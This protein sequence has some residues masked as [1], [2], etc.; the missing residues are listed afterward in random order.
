M[1]D[2][3]S[4]RKAEE[5]K[6]PYLNLKR[7]PFDIVPSA[8]GVEHWVGRPA[9]GK[10]LQ[11][12][13]HSATRVPTSRIV[14]LWATFG[15][16]KTHALRHVEY[17]AGNSNSLAAVYVA[18]PRGIRSFLDIYK[19][20]IDALI[21]KGLLENIGHEL[22]R[23]R[24]AAVATDSERALVRLA[25]GSDEEQRIAAAWLHGDRLLARDVRTLG[26][27][28]RI[29]TVNDAVH[30]LNDVMHAIHEQR[31]VI[32]L[33]DEVQELEELQK[34]LSECVGGMHKLFDLNPRGLTLVFSF[35][36][37]SRTTARTILGPALFDRAADII[38]LPPFSVPEATEFVQDLI[39]V[40]SIDEVL[41]PTPFTTEAIDAIISRLDDSELTP[42]TLMKAFDRILREGE[43]DIASGDMNRIEAS[44]ALQVLGTMKRE[45]LS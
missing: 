45:A 5:N 39:R 41:A 36:T 34:K 38:A 37:G 1:S 27:T 26:L 42:R 31:P 35:T 21:S 20:V 12:L 23:T 32:L 15:S 30:V 7:W 22:L 8:E 44:Y 18:V 3:S 9:I 33:V 24:G 16:G 43:Y 2:A 13:V 17:L 19:A 4:V 11:R 14:L 25:V 40:W 28:R 29:E 10:Q 6:F